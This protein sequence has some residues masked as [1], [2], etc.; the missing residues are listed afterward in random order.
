MRKSHK[1]ALYSIPGWEEFVSTEFYN[2]LPFEE[3][4]EFARNLNLNGKNEW[5]KYVYKSSSF[6]S[7]NIPTHPR[8]TYK[9]SGWVSWGDWL[10]TG[11]ISSKDFNFRSFEESR[12]FVRNLKLNG[13]TAWFKWCK[14]NEKPNDIPSCPSKTYKDSGWV[15]WGDF[16]G[17][18]NIAN[19]NRKFRSFEKARKFSRSLKLNGLSAWCEWRKSDDRPDDIPTNPNTTY[20]DSWI[21]WGDFLGTGYFSRKNMLSHEEARNFAHNLKFSNVRDWEKWRKSGERPDN[22]PS[23]PNDVYKDSG[24]VSWG[25]FLGTSNIKDFNFIPFKEMRIFA[26]NLKLSSNL[27]WRKWCKS[28]KRPDNIP[29]NPDRIYKNSGWVSWGDFLGTGR[30]RRKNKQRKS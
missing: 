7:K 19:H 15:S 13:Q 21:S 4:R 29:A 20:K 12:I 25:D 9:D 22:I 18:G 3:A 8:E 30:V 14:S 27:A 1:K 5:E 24:W 11:N 28:G 2:F 10:G 23:N 6:K 26:R 16:L 17:T